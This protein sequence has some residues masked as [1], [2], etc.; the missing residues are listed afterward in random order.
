MILQGLQLDTYI[1]KAMYMCWYTL[2]KPP[3]NSLFFWVTHT[4]RLWSNIIYG[5]FFS[6]VLLKK[7]GGDSD[8]TV[9]P[10]QLFSGLNNSKNLLGYLQYIW[11]QTPRIWGS[12]EATGGSVLVTNFPCEFSEQLGN[13]ALV[14]L[15]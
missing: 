6:C 12:Q 15:A 3:V 4:V 8:L 1:S 11:C 13:T 14:H 7:D 10:V 5:F 2:L 9:T